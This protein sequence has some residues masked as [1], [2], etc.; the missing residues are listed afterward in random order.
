MARAEQWLLRFQ[1]TLV[2]I[3]YVIAFECL[4]IFRKKSR[5]RVQEQ[6]V[7][8]NV[9]Y[10]CK[11]EACVKAIS[12]SKK[13]RGKLLEAVLDGMALINEKR[14]TPYIIFLVLIAFILDMQHI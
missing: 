5:I 6:K 10:D 9:S 3:F 2:T 4:H 12:S 11:K 1:A 14:T 13:M 7:G 8:E